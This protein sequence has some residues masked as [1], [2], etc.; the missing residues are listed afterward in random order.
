M[1]H[2]VVARRIALAG[3]AALSMGVA[4]SPAE[5]ATAADTV[6]SANH[7]G[8]G[9]VAD[10]VRRV[11]AEWTQPAVS[12]KGAASYSDFRISFARAVHP[13]SVGTSAECHDGTATYFAWI[14]TARHPIDDEVRPGDVL[15]AS[16]STTRSGVNFSIENDTR[17]WGVGGGSGGS[18]GP[19]TMTRAT[20]GAFARS[21]S[22]GILPLADF[23]RVRFTDAL[24]NGQPLDGQ[25][26]RRFTMQ[27]SDGV[28]KAVTTRLA[29]D[30][31]FGVSWR[32]A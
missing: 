20:I 28:V 14:G 11:S 9:V 8:Y 21:D 31:S 16:L 18:G 1:P 3:L 19:P 17:G 2:L 23:G 10:Q 32:H 6:A 7:A 22:T 5:A 15:R 30:G 13:I 12:C 4:G 25:D 27:G 26:P 29:G 24:V